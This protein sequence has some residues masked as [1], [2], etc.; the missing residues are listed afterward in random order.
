[1]S[2]KKT[3]T[4]PIAILILLIAGIVGDILLYLHVHE[5]DSIVRIVTGLG[6]T[7]ALIILLK[8]GVFIK[9]K[10]FLSFTILFILATTI[11]LLFK[12]LHWAGADLLLLIGLT[13]IPFVYTI[14]FLLKKNKNLPDYLKVIWILLLSMGLMFTILHWQY[15]NLVLQAQAILFLIQYAVFVIRSIKIDRMNKIA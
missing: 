4:L 15:G 5:F 8:E 3:I 9:S 10:L 12:I 11:G 1:M 2:Q 14:H 13:G 7:A 6:T